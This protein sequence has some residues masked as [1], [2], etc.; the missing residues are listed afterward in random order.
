MTYR[1]RWTKGPWVVTDHDMIT[2]PN[3]DAIADGGYF[4]HG[5]LDTLSDAPEWEANLRLSA[6]APALFDA[7]EE[8]IGITDRDHVA[9]DRAKEA[10]L[11]ADGQE[12]KR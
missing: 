12:P 2:G 8:I 11:A 10:L 1:K 4:C 7:L 9:W 5:A 6:A 3:G